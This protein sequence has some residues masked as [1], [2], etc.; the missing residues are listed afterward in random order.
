[1]IIGVAVLLGSVV[2]FFYRR[3][4]QDK[5]HVTFREEVPQMPSPE[6]MRLLTEETTVAAD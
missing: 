3:L 5:S 4:V 1:M 6:Q 2:L